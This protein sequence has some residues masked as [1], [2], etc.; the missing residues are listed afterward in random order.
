[1]QI[2]GPDD[3]QQLTT[4]KRLVENGW[5]CCSTTNTI[6]LTAGEWNMRA[7]C[8]MRRESLGDG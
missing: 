1:M 8:A 4:K 2:R 6:K 7:N 3:Q 5:C